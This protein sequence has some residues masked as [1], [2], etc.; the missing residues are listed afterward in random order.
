MSF[1]LSFMSNNKITKNI[2]FPAHLSLPCTKS[3]Q[4]VEYDLT[5]VV[6]HHGS[7]TH[8]GHYIAYVKAPNGSWYEM[9][10]SCVSQVP[11]NRVLQAQAYL[12]FYSQK[13]KAHVAAAPVP[14]PS[15]TIPAPDRTGSVTEPLTAAKKE[16]TTKIGGSVRFDVSVPDNTTQTVKLPSTPRPK[17]VANAA[18]DSD[19][20]EEDSEDEDSSTIASELESDIEDDIGDEGSVE[21]DEDFPPLYC[22]HIFKYKSPLQ[23]FRRWYWSTR[24]NLYKERHLLRKFEY[25]RSGRNTKMILRKYLLVRQHIA[26]KFASES[27]NDDDDDLESALESDSDSDRDLFIKSNKKVASSTKPKKAFEPWENSRGSEEDDSTSSS[28]ESDNSVNE[29]TEQDDDRAPQ[30]KSVMMNGSSKQQRRED[31]FPPKQHRSSDRDQSL[32]IRNMKESKV[33]LQAIAGAKNPSLHTTTEQKHHAVP[34]QYKPQHDKHG[35]HDFKKQGHRDINRN[36][37]Y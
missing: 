11:I 18:M 28:S 19:D 26:G 7:T 36:Q 37:L 27:E 12:L 6:V 16:D 29:R 34:K 31:Q 1:G 13:G 21:D 30:V 5:G 25:Y 2:Q 23:R 33:P 22:T 4:P 3:K 10:D 15:A 32:D 9:N 24:P 17:L 8:S 35:S 14:P 20:D